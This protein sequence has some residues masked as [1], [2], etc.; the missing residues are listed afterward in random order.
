MPTL[1]YPD[2]PSDFQRFAKPVGTNSRTQ[3]AGVA[4]LQA[5]N[6]TPNASDGNTVQDHL[7]DIKARLS[8]FTDTEVFKGEYNN[9]TSYALGDEVAWTDP[10]TSQKAFFKRLAAGGDGGSGTPVSAD[11]ASNWSEINADIHN[12]TV[13]SEAVAANS[14]VAF[15]SPTGDVFFNRSIVTMLLDAQTEAEVTAAVSAEIA[16]VVTNDRWKGT[17]S[18]DTYAV[19]DYA[20]AHG[21]DTYRCILARTNADT[22]GPGGDATGWA[23]VTGTEL[24]VVRRVRDMLELLAQRLGITPATANRGM[25]LS[26]R[27]DGEGYAYDSPPMQFKNAWVSGGTYY[28]GD[29]VIDDSRMHILSAPATVTTPKTGSTPPGS[30]NDWTHI[31][32][33]HT[34]DVSGWRGTYSFSSAYSVG[35]M[36]R[37]RTEYY[38]CRLDHSASATAPDRDPTNWYLLDTWMGTYSTSEYY[39][40]GGIVVYDGGLYWASEYTSPSDA[41]PGEEGDTKWKRLDDGGVQAQI[42]QLRTDL[43]SQIA[44]SRSTHGFAVSRLEQPPT[45]DSEGR[46]WLSGKDSR[47]W[48][49]PAALING[50][51]D[52]STNIGDEAGAYELSAG[53]ENRVRLVIGRYEDPEDNDNI[54]F[55]AF[56][57]KRA[58]AV[59]DGDVGEFLHNPF[60]SGVLG[61]GTEKTSPSQWKNW[62]LIKQ[63]VLLL[64]GGGT[65]LSSLWVAVYGTDDTLIGTVNVGTRGRVV[66]FG[67]V[68]YRY[69]TGTSPNRGAFGDRFNV[70][71]ESIASRTVDIAFRTSENGDDRYFGGNEFA[72]THRPNASETDA[73]V[74][75]NEIHV[76][77]AL[78]RSS[79][80]TLVNN[81]SLVPRTFYATYGT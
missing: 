6:I 69:L 41:D 64:L 30:D 53:V 77:R 44:A 19:G 32:V 38:I 2:S 28:F 47:N 81:G 12:L 35:D 33:G 52:Y 39:P 48:T 49:G 15:R 50:N 14:A 34:S 51:S 72:W 13:K 70:D 5:T 29:V 24:L 76:I 63:N 36:V 75:S 65:E 23:Q 9:S 78:T 18:P 3:P 42:A 59:W 27:V 20:E 55:G 37:H 68:N 43:E 11:N 22:T 21:G 17:W 62:L 80:T 56:T 45:N 8:H 40:Q 16:K 67:D 54:W 25:W 4:L 66:T 60:G 71:T 74:V 58:G 73:N 31:S 79:F 26:R 10:D 46:V 57:R 7:V 1:E 61:V